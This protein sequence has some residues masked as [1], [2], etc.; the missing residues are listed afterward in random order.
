[1]KRALPFVVLAALIAIPASAQLAPGVSG[2][3]T[4]PTQASEAEYWIMIRKLGLCLADSKRDQAVAFLA[5]EPGSTEEDEAFDNIFHRY[6]NRCMG[7]F[8][9]ANII[10]GH[11]RG[12][13]AE[14]L[15]RL[16]PEDR[17]ERALAVA[18]SPPEHVASL[19]DFA[20]CYVA[21]NPLVAR[22]FLLQTKVGT[23]GELEAVRQM[24]VNFGPC[25]PS[26]AEVR[27]D[28]V[29]VRMAVAEALYRVV[30]DMPAE[31]SEGNE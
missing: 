12:S 9:N 11:V 5:T 8:I 24:A 14:G 15:V 20:E 29:D 1:M 22:E 18:L 10:R 28:P 2:Y 19:H 25:I 31:L 17:V 23:K 3:S 27:V 21:N 26:G 13:I 16:M 4:A 6:R 30:H 7:N